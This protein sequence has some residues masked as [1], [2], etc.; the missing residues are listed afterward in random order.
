MGDINLSTDA[1]NQIREAAVESACAAEGLPLAF[2]MRIRQ[3]GDENILQKAAYRRASQMAYDFVWQKMSDTNTWDEKEAQWQT[4]QIASFA[5]RSAVMQLFNERAMVKHSLRS[6]RSYG[7]L[8]GTITCMRCGVFLLPR[9]TRS[10]W[11][12]EW[13]GELAVLPNRLKRAIFLCQL[14]AGMPTMSITLRRKRQVQ[15]PELN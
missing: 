8:P 15:A 14:L 5:A 9:S 1:V 4:H 10:R 2:L 7:A 3:Y 12:I 6:L 11:V 13:C